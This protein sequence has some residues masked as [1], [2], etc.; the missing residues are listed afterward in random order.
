MGRTEVAHGDRKMADKLHATGVADNKIPLGGLV[1]MVGQACVCST[2]L[3][4]LIC[5]SSNINPPPL[6]DEMSEQGEFGDLTIQI[7]NKKGG[8]FGSELS[9][10]MTRLYELIRLTG[11]PR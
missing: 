10:L 4:P 6:S 3:A 11:R 2:G 7:S 8:A 9:I 5:N 1:G